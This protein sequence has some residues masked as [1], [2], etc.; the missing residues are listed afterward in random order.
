[1]SGSPGRRWCVTNGESIQYLLA[2]HLVIPP[3]DK[4]KVDGAKEGNNR[5]VWISPH[6]STKGFTLFLPNSTPY[7]KIVGVGAHQGFAH[8]PIF[9]MV[10]GPNRPFY[11]DCKGKVEGRVGFSWESRREEGE[12]GPPFFHS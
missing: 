1:M 10:G 8:R 4:R 3:K 7:L 9:L 2:S 11:L 6:C 12:P 5:H